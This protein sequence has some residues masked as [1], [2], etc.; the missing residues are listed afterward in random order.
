MSVAS[1]ANLPQP[2]APASRLAGINWQFAQTWFKKSLAIG[3]FLLLWE[4][5]PRLKFVDPL[6][7]PPFSEVIVHGLALAKAGKL[8]PHVLI[9]MQRSMGGFALAV[10]TAVPL[11]ILLGWY[12]PLERYCNPLL[13]FLRQ[14]N[15]ISLLPI[16]ILFFGVGYFTKVAM[17]YWVVVWPILLSTLSG[18]KYVDPVL[19]KYGRSLSLSDWQILTKIVAPF[20]VPSIIAGMRIAATYSFLM[21][22]IAEEVGAGSGLG[23]LIFNAQYLLGIHIL[24]VAVLV[25]ALLGFAANHLLVLL[26]RRLTL[27]RSDTRGD[28]NP[29]R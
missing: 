25:L 20:A 7:L 13:Q 8:L 4:L 26:E 19:V 21:L 24:Y 2:P 5:A 18:V 6:F 22:I 9:S 28:A 11:G 15:A 16:F 14:F 17:I 1:S 10:V 29:D 12:A 27:W 23:F 3:L